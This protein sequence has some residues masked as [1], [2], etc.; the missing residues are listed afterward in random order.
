MKKFLF[1]F[2]SMALMVGSVGCS[3]GKSNATLDTFIKAYT[4]AGIEVNAKEKPIF[5]M[6]GAQNGVVFKVEDKKTAVYEYK[7]EKELKKAKTDNSLVKDWPSNGRFLL[8][9]DSKKA[10]EIFNGVK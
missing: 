6:I 2:L 1:I 7:S 4:D 8:E 10:I 5:T 9:S 3:S